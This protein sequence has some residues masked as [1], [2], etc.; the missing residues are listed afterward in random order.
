MGIFE[1]KPACPSPPPCPTCPVCPPCVK[2]IDDKTLLSY[3]LLMLEGLD[4]DLIKQ[5][6]VTAQNI[7]LKAENLRKIYGEIGGVTGELS[8]SRI[9]ENVTRDIID[10]T[11]TLENKSTGA[12]IMKTSPNYVILAVILL[13]FAVAS[14]LFLIARRK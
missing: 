13:I 14:G 4:E 9:R 2:N 11:L 12:F 7:K 5:S 6:R 10:W 8:D 3:R 1:S